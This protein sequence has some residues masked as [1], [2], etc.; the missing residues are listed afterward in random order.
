MLIDCFAVIRK[1]RANTVR[2]YGFV[3]ILTFFAVGA[4]CGRPKKIRSNII[5]FRSNAIFYV[6]FVGEGLAPPEK[7]KGYNQFINQ[8][9]KYTLSV[10]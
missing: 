2:P 8:R 7:N 4:T 9:A 6:L 10:T 3:Q 5:E 1:T